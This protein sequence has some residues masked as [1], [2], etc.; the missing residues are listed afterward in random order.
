MRPNLRFCKGFSLKAVTAE[1]KGFPMQPIPDNI[2]AF[3]TQ[4][5]V[6]SIAAAADG[7]IWS[8]CC[9]YVFDAERAAL[10]VLTSLET[11]HG[12]LMAANP[13]VA[14][15][16]AG[17]PGSIAKISGIQFAARAALLEEETE[18]R[19]AQSLFYHAHPAARALKSDV[20]L[21]RLDTVKFTDNKLVFAQKTLWQRNG[22]EAA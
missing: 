19:R 6:V 2:A 18:R 13:N 3:L 1:Y 17:Q 8:A 4:N 21:L 10:V 7:A 9:F 15:T 20:W 16:I 12:S 22:A 14:G 5:H 11:R